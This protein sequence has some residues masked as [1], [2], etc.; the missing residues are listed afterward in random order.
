MASVLGHWTPV[1]SIV[2]PGKIVRYRLGGS[3]LRSPT[4]PHGQTVE[5]HAVGIRV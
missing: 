4:H 3:I 5:V 1:W 2:W